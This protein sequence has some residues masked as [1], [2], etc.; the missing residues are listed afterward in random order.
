[1]QSYKRPNMTILQSF[2]ESYI[3]ASQKPADDKSPSSLAGYCQ[4]LL[5]DRFLPSDELKDAL[6][7]L[8]ERAN[9]PI[10]IAI[11]GQFSSGKSTFLNAILSRT[12]LPTGITPVT[13]KVCHIVYGNDFSLSAYY[14]DGQSTNHPVE[15]IFSLKDSP[16]KQIDYFILSAPVAIL[17]EISFLDTPGFNSQRESDTQTTER[18]LESVDGIIWLTLIDNAGKQSEFEILQKFLPNYAHKSLCVLNQKDRLAHAHDINTAIDYIKERFSMFFADVVAISSLLALRSRGFDKEQILLQSLSNL[19]R[20]IAALSATDYSQEILEQYLNEQRKEVA[21]LYIDP[22]KTQELYEE[23]GFEQ[24]LT[25]INQQIRPSANAAKEHSIKNELERLI[26]LLVGQYDF[27]LSL[28]HDLRTIINE[29]STRTQD[30]L[31]NLKNKHKQELHALALEL[32]YHIE[33]I[34]EILF[35]NLIHET[36]THF[37]TKEAFIGTRILQHELHVCRLN[38]DRINEEL[39]LGDS[40][41][42]KFFKNF[43]IKIRKVAKH[44]KQSIEEM[45]DDFVAEI[46]IWQERCEFIQKTNPIVSDVLLVNLKHYALKIHQDITT[47]FLHTTNEMQSFV[48]SEL[49]A[50]P[51]FFKGT[52]S[53][54]IEHAILSLEKR[55]SDSVALHLSDSHA[56]KIFNPTFDT[57]KTILEES[58]QIHHGFSSISGEETIA[59]KLYQKIYIAYQELTNQELQQLDS[60]VAHLQERK[61]ELHNLQ[62]KIKEQQDLLA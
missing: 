42:V 49:E 60:R 16:T 22:S 3:K 5:H 51:I 26:M 41:N 13:S 45:H 27:L 57:I 54:L 9:L 7:T 28:L 31:K 56:F 11:I 37:T 12:L 1:M 6:N 33:S 29:H 59:D 44:I 18:I 23:S 15:D 8:Q 17:K 43:Q 25:F 32:N 55:I 53:K 38:H 52:H 4:M 10:K 40:R 47:P 20:K 61:N 21:E 46:T 39:F 35:N 30:L 19:G 58:F 2:I 50:L 14:T 24:V 62:Q 34:T 48:S 36:Q